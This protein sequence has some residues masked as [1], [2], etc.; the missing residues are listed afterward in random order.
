MSAIPEDGPWSSLSLDFYGPM[1]NR[2]YLL[3]LID[4]NTRYPIVQT[5]SSTSFRKTSRILDDIFSMFGVS[6]TI[7]TE[8][9]QPVN[10]HEFSKFA[11][12]QGFKHRRVTLLW[13]QANG[14][15][16]RFMKKLGKVLRDAKL[17]QTSFEDELLWFLR[18]YRATPHSSTKKSPNELLLGTQSSTSRLPVLRK[19]DTSDLQAVASVND[20]NAKTAMKKYVDSHRHVKS[21]SFEIGEYR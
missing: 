9:G 16:E 8:N 18:S 19:S 7:R 5:T 11:E 17:D 6:H 15:T 4:D 20:N 14:I 13:P 12:S 21:S 3:V 2:Q 1:N 10:G